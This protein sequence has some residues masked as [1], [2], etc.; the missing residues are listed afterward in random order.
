MMMQPKTHNNFH[1][2][3]NV[4]VT[5][6]QIKACT[7]CYMKACFCGVILKMLLKASVA[8]TLAL[9]SNNH[10]FFRNSWA[11][12]GESSHFVKFNVSCHMPLPMW[13]IIGCIS[14]AS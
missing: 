14:Y 8:R 10:R 7:G 12:Y 4:N 1:I 3:C 13:H 6:V 11:L 2:H 5:Y 9:E